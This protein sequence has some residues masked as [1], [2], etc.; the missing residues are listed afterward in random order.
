MHPDAGDEVPLDVPGAEEVGVVPWPRVFRNRVRARVVAS[1]RHRWIVLSAALFGLFTVGFTITILAVSLPRIAADLDSTQAT[2]TWVI[3][4]PLLALGVVGPAFG[5]LGD[6]WGQRRVYLLGLAAAGVLAAA[7]ALAPSA[8]ALILFRV[9]GAVGGAATGPASMAMIARVFPRE[10]R[11]Q[12]L[13]LWSLVM[14][15][16][17]VLGV[18]AG[19]PVVEAFGWRWIFVGQVVFTA[20]ALVVAYAV[21]PDGRRSAGGGSFDWAGAVVLAAGV[22]ALLV[23]L[24]RGPEWG[25]TSPGVLLAFAAAPA[26]L[27][28]FAAVE[29][30]SPSP[31]VPL[32]YLRRRNVVVPMAAGALT[33]FAYMGGFI[34]TPLLLQDV[35]GY[36]ETR[37]G[38]LAIARPLTFAVAGPL[39]GWL[40]VRI[41]E[42]ISAV[43]GAVVVAASMVALAGVAPGSGDLAVVVALA[44]SGLGLGASAPA[45]SASVAN[46]VDEGDL[47]VAGAAYQLATQVGVVAGIQVMQT[48]QATREATSGLVGSYGDAFVTGAL[49]CV[50]GAVA[51]CFLRSTPRP[52]PATA[53]AEAAGRVAD[54]RALE[55]AAAR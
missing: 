15:G 52:A 11:V 47:G 24:N 22:T 27:A 7:T 33:Q 45:L 48:V 38:L 34:L 30:R 10:R 26:G 54:E 16:A 41:G 12:A 32:D 44:L 36:G 9:L 42:R 2:L 4:G 18:V 14:A 50:L 37:T 19:G 1:D 51:A 49:A 40:A 17:P 8:G 39:A 6:L 20:A 3:T 25:W 5:K 29:R 13:G 21:L 35:L 23:G 46:A 31:M 43:A 28:A 55:V 53:A